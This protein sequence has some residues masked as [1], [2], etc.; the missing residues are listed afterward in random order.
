MVRLT[1]CPDL[2]LD[3]YRGRKTIIQPTNFHGIHMTG[4]NSVF[5]RTEKIIQHSYYNTFS[6]EISAFPR[7]ERSYWWKYFQ[8]QSL[9]KILL[10]YPLDT[11]PVDG[12]V[13]SG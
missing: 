3:F 7:L 1:D 5:A 11:C 6:L 9:V 4:H 2:T 8:L 10:P 12:H 13:S